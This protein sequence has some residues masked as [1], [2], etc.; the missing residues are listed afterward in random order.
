MPDH[1]DLLQDGQHQNS[2]VA[3]E[4]LRGAGGVPAVSLHL[5]PQL[6]GWGLAPRPGWGDAACDEGGWSAQG[7]HQRPQTGGH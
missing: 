5:Q 3:G 4:S 2:C 6:P 7:P 1:F